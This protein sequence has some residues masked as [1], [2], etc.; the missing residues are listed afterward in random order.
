MNRSEDV[1]THTF[2]GIYIPCC[3][4][5]ETDCPCICHDTPPDDDDESSAA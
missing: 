1:R 3:E 4:P 2:S 5:D